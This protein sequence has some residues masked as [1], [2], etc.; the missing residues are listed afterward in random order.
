M[1]SYILN[2]IYHCLQTL[3]NYS[4]NESQVSDL[5]TEVYEA[6]LKSTGL[7]NR[8][9][10]EMNTSLELKAKLYL[11]DILLYTYM[12]IIHCRMN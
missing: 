6:K 11:L 7:N 2:F 4:L 10:T 1:Y 9:E 12:V 5:E 3:G 8:L